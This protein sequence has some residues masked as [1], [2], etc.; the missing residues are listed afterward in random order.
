MS[1]RKA[2]GVAPNLRFLRLRQ[3]RKTVDRV[4]AECARPPDKHQ[5]AAGFTTTARTIEP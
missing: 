3:G 4:A 1:P 5:D 2:V